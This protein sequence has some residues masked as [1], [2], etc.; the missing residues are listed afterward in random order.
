VVLYHSW[1]LALSVKSVPVCGVIS[2][3]VPGTVC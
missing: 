2:Q 3:L 1:Y